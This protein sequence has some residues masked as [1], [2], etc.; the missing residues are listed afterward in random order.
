MGDSFAERLRKQRKENHLTQADLA[1]KIG[2]SKAAVAMWEKGTRMPDSGRLVRIADL[3]D[4]RLDYMM[5]RTDDESSL[6]DEDTKPQ[7]WELEDQFVA[8]IKMYLSLDNFGRSA[9]ENLVRSECLRCHNQQTI[10]DASDIKISLQI[11]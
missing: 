9:I 4:K 5:G 7:K 1:A 8:I 2:V 6:T 3:F 10:K 11:R